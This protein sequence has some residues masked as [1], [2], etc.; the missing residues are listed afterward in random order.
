[1]A[2]YRLPRKEQIMNGSNHRNVEMPDTL[3]DEQ[4]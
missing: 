2:V 1:L 3:T 4:R